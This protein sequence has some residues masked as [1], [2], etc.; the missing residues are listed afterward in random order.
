M[1]L[2]KEQ[3]EESRSFYGEEACIHPAMDAGKIR[4]PYL[5]VQYAKNYM[6]VIGQDGY[7]KKVSATFCETLGYSEEE[8]FSRPFRE[9]MVIAGL[10]TAGSALGTGNMNYYFEKIFYCKGGQVLKI[11]WRSVPDILENAVLIV[12]WK[13]K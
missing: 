6:C 11:T 13:T 8:L 12:G 7:L 5:F 2:K 3:V 10:E 4:L 1:E 9:F